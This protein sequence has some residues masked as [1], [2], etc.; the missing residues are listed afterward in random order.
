MGAWVD[1]VEVKASAIHEQLSAARRLAEGSKTLPEVI[2]RPYLELL[3]RL[4]EEEFPFARMVDSSDLVAR[5]SGPAVASPDPPVGIVMSVFSDLREQ[6]R[7]VAR[8][9]VG[10]N[11]D[12]RLR[13]PAELDPQLAGVTRGSLVVGLR[14]PNPATEPHLGQISIPEVTEPIFEAVRSAVR[15]LALV[16][17]HV[18]PDRIDDSLGADFPDP[19]I[20]DTVMV[21]VSRLAPTGRRGIE[22]VSLYGP[23]AT[24]STEPRPLTPQSRYLLKQALAQPPVRVRDLGRFEGVVREIDLDA[25]RFEVRGIETIGALRCAYGPTWSPI[26]R[27][28]LDARVRVVGAYE[29]LPNRQPRF[30]TV[31]RIEVLSPPREQLHLEDPR[32]GE[33]R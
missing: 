8:A 17:R 28:M 33:P 30:L 18:L 7:R 6:I 24:G 10:L 19:A 3:R 1:A 27:E 2:A 25:M 20:R 12:R 26:V 32:S 9:I 14:V 31:D 29:S 16:T 15:S 11:T 22:S 13:W 21:A 23:A 5:F 4:Y